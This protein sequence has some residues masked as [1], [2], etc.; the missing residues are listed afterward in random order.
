MLEVSLIFRT[1][2]GNRIIIATSTLPKD[3]EVLRESILTSLNNVRHGD[4]VMLAAKDIEFNRFH[5]LLNLAKK[6]HAVA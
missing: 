4:D 6:S 2:Q 3:V 5:A 1:P